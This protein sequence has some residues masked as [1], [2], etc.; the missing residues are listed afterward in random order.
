[1]TQD[2]TQA[3]FQLL[4]N[5]V[6]LLA[7]GSVIFSAGLLVAVVSLVRAARSDKALESA[8]EKLYQS[9]PVGV[10]GTIKEVGD[11]AS[12]VGGLIGDITAPPQ[13]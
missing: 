6:L 2:Q 5:L 9:A 8:I 4:A 10:Q 7:S 13:A 11:L 3:I 12:S 1:M